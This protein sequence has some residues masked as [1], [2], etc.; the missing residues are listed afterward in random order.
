VLA[1]GR[2]LGGSCTKKR[3]AAYRL[4]SDVF[5]AVTSYAIGAQRP[6]PDGRF[7]LVCSNNVPDYRKRTPAKV[8]DVIDGVEFVDGTDQGQPIQFN[9]PRAPA[10]ADTALACQPL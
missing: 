9:R 2:P 5:W 8:I 6:Q 7:G 1:W 3:V 4:S 10:E